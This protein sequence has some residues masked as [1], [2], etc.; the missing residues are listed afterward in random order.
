MKQR[1]GTGALSLRRSI[2]TSAVVL[3]GFLVLQVVLWITLGQAKLDDRSHLD[4]LNDFLAHSGPD[5]AEI[6]GYIVCEPAYSRLSPETLKSSRV[7]LQE[8]GLVLLKPQDLEGE[9]QKDLGGRDA[10][11]A[12]PEV[13]I[14]SP[15]LG[16]A[17]V[18]WRPRAF[19][20]PSGY[21][22]YYVFLFGRWLRVWI[23]GH[24]S[25]W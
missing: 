16:V 12:C 23:G 19:Y 24:W 20:S 13:R 5:D 11:W 17:E 25:Q 1:S 14:S 10:F 18:T 7:K 9:W 8:H 2:R 15:L 3:V 21:T 4:Q 22:S 6:G